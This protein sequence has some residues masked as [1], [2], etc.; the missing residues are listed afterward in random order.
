MV[1]FRLFGSIGL[2]GD[3]G[4][5]IL[6]VLAQPKRIAL[7][8]FLAS[9]RPQCF[10]RRDTIVGLFWPE[11]DQKRSRAALRRSLHFLRLFLGRDIFLCRGNEGIRL[12][13]KRFWCD[14]QAFDEFLGRGEE[15]EAIRLYRGD[16]LTGFFL[17]GL[18]GLDEWIEE[19][20]AARRDAAASAM[21]TVAHR[22]I[23]SGKVT[24]GELM[25][26]KA[27]RLVCSAE[28]QVQ[29]FVAA[30]S[31]AGERAGAIQFYERF[32]ERL[33][34]TLSLEP[35]SDSQRL[36]RTLRAQEKE[37]KDTGRSKAQSTWKVPPPKTSAEG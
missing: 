1:E 15:G 11:M 36:A 9:A 34:S 26:K 24:E 13:W 25:G 19:E 7:L 10:L 29:R 6:P 14:V 12:D 33:Q 16:F 20:R 31:A 5:E 23:E 2:R 32:S 27:L 3:D 37:Q 18:H 28:W 21:W 35:S 8:A 4:E 17:R 22:L 30:L